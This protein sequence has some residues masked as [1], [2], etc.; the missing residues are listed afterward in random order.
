TQA[1]VLGLLDELVTDDDILINAAGSLPGDLHKLWRTRSPHQY[2]VEY[3]YSCM[4]YEIPAAIGVQLA[5]PGSP[6]WALVGDGTYLM[7]P[8]EIVTAVQQ[9]LPVK[10][11]VLQNHGYA[12]I[13]GL[14]ESVGAERFGTAYRHRAADGGFTGPP[15]PVDL[16]ANA[17]SLG[18]RVLRAD[19]V[20]ELR[21]ALAVARAQDRPTCVYVETETA[22]TVS[23]PP[24]AQAWWDV[25]V[26]GTATRPSA[27]RAREEYERHV[28]DRRSHL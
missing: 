23:G 27:A 11:V 21:E 13:G 17:A 14:S 9:E 8:T 24:P 2:H 4:G 20:G 16:A 25:P 22:D 7:N 6:V 15:L 19:T 26:A 3:G 5:A 10:L 28:T 12:S 18:M 1:Q